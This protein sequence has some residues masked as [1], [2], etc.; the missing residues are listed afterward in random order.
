MFAGEDE[1]NILILL[2]RGDHLKEI[3]DD[4]LKISHLY[5][6]Y[7]L[8]A[9]SH[10]ETD[11]YQFW[12][13]PFRQMLCKYLCNF[14]LAQCEKYL[15]PWCVWT[16]I[17]CYKAGHLDMHFFFYSWTKILLIRK[18][19]WVDRVLVTTHLVDHHLLFLSNAWFGLR[20]QKRE[21]KD[22]KIWM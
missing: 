1:C 4:F 3:E 6:F 8:S 19:S 2:P 17:V 11:L 20:P 13:F 18:N 12:F 7:T 10:I 9:N 21:H 5:L 14:C 22:Y 15:S 16:K